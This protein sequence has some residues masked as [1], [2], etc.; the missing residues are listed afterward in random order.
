MKTINFS[1]VLDEIRSK[2]QNK[3][4]FS[5]T[6][7]TMKLGWSDEEQKMIT[8]NVDLAQYLDL[9]HFVTPLNPQGK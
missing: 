8:E 3:K 6:N 5:D 9:N 2:Q 4:H 7:V 1:E